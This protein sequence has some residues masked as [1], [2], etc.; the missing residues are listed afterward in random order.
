[1]KK[2]IARMIARRT[3]ALTP[4]AMPRCD[5]PD[6][7]IVDGDGVVGKSLLLLV[8]VE[9]TV[10]RPGN[11]EGKLLVSPL[12][13]LVVD[14]S[15][16][17]LEELL[18][19]L[20]VTVELVVE[21]SI[22]PDELLESVLETVAVIEVAVLI[23]EDRVCANE[24][25]A[26]VLADAPVDV[27]SVGGVLGIIVEEPSV[28][29]DEYSV[30]VSV[31]VVKIVEVLNVFVTSYPVGSGEA[32]VTNVVSKE[33]SVSTSVDWVVGNMVVVVV[34]V[35]VVDTFNPF[36]TVILV[37]A[38]PVSGKSVLNPSMRSCITKSPKCIKRLK[39]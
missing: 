21:V 37:I 7:E 19:K 10:E 1:M 3:K 12:V 2:T 8:T 17:E 13:E 20:L 5:N 34:V 29:E 30:D 9:L 4:M 35:V 14:T 11:V 18:E 25:L 31:G 38:R 27:A 32:S 28:T 6:G 24:E 39:I 26:V 15:N 22:K 33:V 16:V 36:L 23:V